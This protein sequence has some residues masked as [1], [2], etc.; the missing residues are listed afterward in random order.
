MGKLEKVIHQL[1]DDDSAAIAQSFKSSK[2][3][4]FLTLFEQVRENG[5]V[6]EDTSSSF[7][8]LKSRLYDKVQEYLID[9]MEEPRIDVLKKVAAIPS[10]I[11]DTPRDTA[12]A[13]LT[14]L[15]ADLKEFDMPNELTEVYAAFKKSIPAH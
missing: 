8:T 15:E 14:K 12:I 9:N 3:D 1:S 10:L 6:A 5:A 2:A 4:K 11:Y 7:Y 13:I